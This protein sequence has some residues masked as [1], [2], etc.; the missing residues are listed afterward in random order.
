MLMKTLSACGLKNIHL[1]DDLVAAGV[2]H[3]EVGIL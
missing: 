1:G 2:P 3:M